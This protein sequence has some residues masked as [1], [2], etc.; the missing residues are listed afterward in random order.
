MALL[1]LLSQKPQSGYD[2]RKTFATTALRH[3]SDSPG[4]IY[5][6]L[7]RLEDRGLIEKRNGE[8]ADPRRRQDFQLTAEG[9][10]ALVN[11]LEAPLTREDVRMRA[12]EIM[13][14]FAFMD[15]NVPRSTAARFLDQF[16]VEMSAYAAESRA[17][18]DQMAAMVKRATGGEPLHTGLLAFEAGIEGMEAQVNWARRARARFAAAEK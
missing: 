11:W 12:A 6:A 2:L 18:W 7:R 17:H 13:L 8:S 3:Y 1:G 15:G 16:I 14:R 9:R 4:S 5:P 10:K